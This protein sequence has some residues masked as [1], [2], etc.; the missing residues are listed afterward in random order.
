MIPSFL[1]S[2]A[3]F[4]F[5]ADRVDLRG[6]QTV[7]GERQ[8]RQQ[9]AHGGN[10]VNDGAESRLHRLVGGHIVHIVHGSERNAQQPLRDGGA[11]LVEEGVHRKHDALAAEAQLVFGVVDGVHQHRRAGDG[12]HAGEG[13]A[14]AEENEPRHRAAAHSERKKTRHRTRGARRDEDVLFIKAADEGGGDGHAEDHANDKAQADVG[15]VGR[16]APHIHGKVHLRDLAHVVHHVHDQQRDH[17]GLERRVVKD[18]VDVAAEGD[19]FGR[20]RDALP[21]HKT[22]QKHQ[23]RAHAGDRC[24]GR[25]VGR[26][27]ALAAERVQKGHAAH[28]DDYRAERAADLAQRHHAVLFIRVMR[29]DRRDRPDGNVIDRVGHSPQHIA[30]RRHGDRSHGRAAEIPEAQHGGHDDDERPRQQVRAEFA[31][32]RL[33]A[34]GDHAHQDVVHRV[35]QAGGHHDDGHAFRGDAQQVR[36]EKHHVHRHKAVDHVLPQQAAGV[37]QFLRI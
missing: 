15:N 19:A 28:G 35:P 21:Q 17:Q 10:D 32:A 8:D 20:R 14:D 9:E 1:R 31:P 11:E 29:G 27:A 4:Q 18:G 34:V 3:V 36:E 16:V 6:L 26:C 23:K 2:A 12:G 37:G 22:A 30:R 13:E 24:G 7:E 25:R 5:G 33:G